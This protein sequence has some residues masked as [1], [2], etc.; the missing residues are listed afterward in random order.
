MKKQQ[1]A[2]HVMPVMAVVSSLRIAS[3]VV[4]GVFMVVVYAYIAAISVN[5]LT[6]GN[7]NVVVTPHQFEGSVNIVSSLIKNAQTLAIA[8]GMFSLLLSLAPLFLIKTKHVA[9]RFAYN[10]I[11]LGAMIAGMAYFAQPIMAQLISKV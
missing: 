1:E 5:L 3:A 9:Q 2:E 7:A 10:G 8:F 11:V 4:G 6:I